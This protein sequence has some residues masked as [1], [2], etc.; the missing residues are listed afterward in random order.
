MARTLSGK[1]IRENYL[2]CEPWDSVRYRPKPFCACTTANLWRECYE[3]EAMYDD[4]SGD[5][6]AIFNRWHAVR[7]ELALRE[8][9]RNA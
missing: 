5:D 2:E 6:E 1:T 9:R 8:G 4:A 3:L 7:F